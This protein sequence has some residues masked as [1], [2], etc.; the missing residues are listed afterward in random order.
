MY[1]IIHFATALLLF[2]LPLLAGTE[3]QAF[4]EPVV[5]P[6][7]V[8]AEIMLKN[9]VAGQETHFVTHGKYASCRN[10]ECLKMLGLAAI[11]TYDDDISLQMVADKSVDRYVGYSIHKKGSG[12]IF[13][14]DSEAGGLVDEPPQINGRTL[15]ATAAG[16]ISTGFICSP[17]ETLAL[18]SL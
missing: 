3:V 8:T 15:S 10:E 6:Y 9:V 5:S 11:V 14:W 13:Y 7:D 2:V 12:K 17:G 18:T 16:G 1:T 4:P